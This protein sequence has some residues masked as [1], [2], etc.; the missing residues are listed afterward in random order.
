MSHTSR[1]TSGYMLHRYEGRR[2]RYV[3]SGTCHTRNLSLP[4]TDEKRVPPRLHFISP[5]LPYIS[6]R[7]K[8]CD[9]CTNYLY[10]IV[11]FIFRSRHYRDDS[12][13]QY[14]SNPCIV[15]IGYVRKSSDHFEYP[16]KSFITKIYL[17]RFYVSYW[18]R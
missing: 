6:L 4:R 11:S 10:L 8:Y 7:F 16:L 13:I 2:G 12:L 3:D 18:T 9:F 5:F 15:E 1:G 14:G 17:N